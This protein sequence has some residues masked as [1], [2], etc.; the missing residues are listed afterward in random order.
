MSGQAKV[1]SVD[2]LEA[3]RS[4]LIVFLTKARESV[5]HTTDAVRRMRQW[6][7]HDQRTHWEAQIRIRQ[8]K[9]DQAEAELFSAKLSS[10]RDSLSRQQMMV[11][12][13]REAMAEAHEKLRNVKKW[14]R[15][16]DSVM[17]PLVKRMNPLRD[18]LDHDLQ[19]AVAY[20]SQAQTTLEAYAETPMSEPGPP[21]TT[22]G[23]P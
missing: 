3:F 7:E 5:D 6:L 15:D 1:T 19:H 18:F 21:A 12:R 2:V 11:R 20:L 10:F 14:H 13:A 8:R 17:D 22:E 4:S 9:L 16:F 23:Q